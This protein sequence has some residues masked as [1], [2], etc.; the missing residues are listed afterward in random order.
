MRVAQDAAGKRGSVAPA[1]IRLLDAGPVEAQ[2]RRE[3]EAVLGGIRAAG[4]G[5]GWVTPGQLIEGD[6]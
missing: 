2:R 1:A 5:S 6:R 3:G 4:I